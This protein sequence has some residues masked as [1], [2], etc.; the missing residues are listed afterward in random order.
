[1][2]ETVFS[3]PVGDKLAFLKEAMRTGYQVVLC[4]IG[5]A[6]A[7]TSDQ[8]AAMRVS[9]GG[10]DVPL[11]KL[12]ARFP[13]TLANLRAA[14][15]VLPQVIIFE[16]DDLN[17]PFKRVAVFENGKATFLAKAPPVW[18][19][20]LL[21]HRRKRVRLPTEQIHAELDRLCESAPAQD[22]QAAL[23]DLRQ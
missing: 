17:Y 1:M 7:E 9:Q 19:I 18:F 15:P 2:F 4:F 3:D 5:I 21:Q 20:R 12:V 23:R 16:N 22:T 14:I 11:E 8:R 13:R 10:H 6:S